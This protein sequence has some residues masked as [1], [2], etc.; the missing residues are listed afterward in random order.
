M[1][2]PK[3]CIFLVVDD[4]G[5]VREILTQYLR[6]FGFENILQAKNGRAALKI[7]QNPKQ[8]IDIV[9]SDW[10][11]PQIDGLTLLRAIRKDPTR[12]KM[13]FLMVSSQGSHERMKITK[14]A[15]SH[16]DAYLVKP[17]R[18]NDLKEK[19]EKL[20]NGQPD[21]SAK[22]FDAVF[23]TAPTPKS[24]NTTLT[25]DLQTMKSEAIV[26]LILTHQRV[27]ELE[28][29]IALG[30]EALKY[31]PDHFELEF[32]IGVTH[33]LKSDYEA[34]KKHFIRVLVLKPDHIEAKN[35]LNEINCQEAA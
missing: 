3:K 5:Q 7:I 14:A 23:A 6:S 25:Y 24:A 8:N 9:I 16:V 10:E 21:E 28:K 18:A 35:F 32:S 15:K 2:D 1:R 27:G 12:S 33:F 30:N 31:F 17:F 29:A 34:S 19:V 26:E 13:K 4:D 11:M 20:A 22:H